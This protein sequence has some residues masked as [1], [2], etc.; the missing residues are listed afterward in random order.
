MEPANNGVIETMN[1]YFNDLTL[2]PSSTQNLRFLQEMMDVWD[3]FMR[4]TN[5]AAKSMRT[6]PW[7]ESE[8]LVALA[9]EI[10]QS[11]RKDLMDFFY[12][13]ILPGYKQ[14]VEPCDE[15]DLAEYW[16]EVAPGE[17]M[18]CKI[19]SWALVHHGLTFGLAS[20]RF[21]NQPSPAVELCGE[22]YD[23]TSDEIVSVHAVVDCVTQKK[24]LDKIQ[25]E[26]SV[27]Q[28]NVDEVC[29]PPD[30]VHRRVNGEIVVLGATSIKEL[31]R[32]AADVGFEIK[33]FNFIPYD[34]V[35]NYDCTR[36]KGASA[37]AAIMCGPV[38]HSGAG[39]GDSS[40]LID[41]ISKEPG[42]PPVELLQESRGKL[43][44]TI[45]SFRQGLINLL[46]RNV[47]D[48]NYD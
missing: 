45:S 1:V 19:L 25:Y 6:V 38:P 39:M 34:K 32:V 22:K 30:I 42:Y 3:E 2:A 13:K 18:S 40:C 46:A 48:R 35:A 8:R 14:E 4:R 16:V 28:D 36:W 26:R 7:E 37:I 23:L 10:S 21:W 20:S 17:K 44:V 12:R 11:G 31:I 9:N 5:G 43:K 15:I 29:D 33:R 27:V 41:T 24:H 47:I